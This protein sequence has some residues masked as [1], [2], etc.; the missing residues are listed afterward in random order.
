MAGVMGMSSA[1]T[2]VRFPPRETTWPGDDFPTWL[3]PMLVKE[4]RQGVQSGVFFWTFLILQGAMFLLCSVFVLNGAEGRD[5]QAAFA[6]FFWTAAV[7]TIAVVVPLRGLG[8]IAGERRGNGLDLLQVTRL[9]ATRIVT[10]KWLAIIAQSALIAVTL[11]PYVVLRYFFG[12]VDVLE[13]IEILGWI[14][15]IGAVVAAAALALSTLPLWLRI[16]IVV[17]VGGMLLPVIA[18][19]IDDGIP[20]WFGRLVLSPATKGAILAIL[21]V[22]ALAFLEFAASRIAPPAEN[23]AG[24]KRLLALAVA[25]AWPITG[26]LGT[27]QAAL[28]TFLATAPLLICYAVGTIVD[29]PSRVP[30]LFAPFRRFAAAGRLAAALFTPGWATGIPFLAILFATC[31]AGWLGCVQRFLPPQAEPPALAAAV[32]V[33]ATVVYPLPCVVCFSR[34]GQ[35]LLVVLLVQLVCFLSFILANVAKPFGTPWPDYAWGW[36]AT[37]PFPLGAACSL[38]AIAERTSSPTRLANI[39]PTFAQAGLA[40]LC[41]ALA[42]VVRPWLREIGIGGDLVRGRRRDGRPLETA[43]ADASLPRVM[44]ERPAAPARPWRWSGDDFPGWLPAMLVRELRQGVQSGFFIWTFIGIQAAMFVLMAWAASVLGPGSNRVVATDIVRWFWVT[45]A[46][47]IGIVLPL[48]GLAAVSSERAGNNLDL[49]RLSRLSA[50]RIIVGKWLA[51]AAQGLLVA[52]ALLPYLV[53]RYFFGGVNVLG[54]LGAFGWIVIV[55]LAVAA[56]ALA[57]STLPGWVRIGIGVLLAVVGFVPAVAIFNDVSRTGGTG[58]PNLDTA[59]QLGVI[60]ILA[61]Y[62]LALLEYA[63][64]RIAAPAENHAGRKRLLA[65]VIAAAWVVMGC[66]GSPEGFGWTAATTGPLL[67]CFAIGSLVEPPLPIAALHHPFGRF[68]AFGRLAAALFTPGWATGLV[69]VLILA[70][71]CTTG[72]LTFF[73]RMIAGGVRGF[74]DDD[75]TVALTLGLLVVATIL[76][77]L[78]FLVR[79]PA[80]VT[81]GEGRSIAQIA[82][83]GGSLIIYGLVQLACLL[84]FVYAMAVNVWTDRMGWLF[85]LPFPLAALCAY[86]GVI[87]DQPGLGTL[88]RFDPSWAFI[89]AAVLTTLVGLLVV[90]APWCRA[91]RATQRLSRAARR[92]P[93]NR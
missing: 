93:S 56:A 57:V 64:A 8:G 11:L 51:I 17:L 81:R 46:G 48:R 90:A 25:A 16:G 32:L 50:T 4:L 10:G 24:R 67:L 74:G 2:N 45:M 22:H 58:M 87:D 83:R 44:R 80:L 84:V 92:L 59:E 69:F 21:A 77:P 70:G 61:A 47:V 38:A 85:T 20:R 15:V 37:L 1:E 72:W 18:A 42:A 40:V 53:L 39:A 43:L 3:P 55:S 54:E 68:G 52:T 34:L 65:L 88:T 71:L 41:V 5:E 75:F 19:I 14:V 36:F 31:L 66:L 7:A 27:Q 89:A 13:Q 73:A 33:I 78:P 62:T 82:G 9:S 28:G 23:H 26:W 86:P 49:V 60:A 91:M 76:Y 29:V 12:G 6:F 79:L 63:A 35:G 30:T